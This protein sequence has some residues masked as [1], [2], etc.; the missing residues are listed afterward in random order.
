MADNQISR[1]AI[2]KRLAQLRAEAEKVQ[3]DMAQL[4]A[5]LS[6]YAG[7]IEDCEYW[8]SVTLSPERERGEEKEEP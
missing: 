6:A 7:A 3:T 2:E 4:Q 5:N 1:D 8:L